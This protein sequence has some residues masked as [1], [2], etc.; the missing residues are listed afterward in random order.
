MTLIT[1]IGTVRSARVARQN[2]VELFLSSRLRVYIQTGNMNKYTFTFKITPTVDVEYALTVPPFDVA[3]RNSLLM[4]RATAEV[5]DEQHLSK[6]ADEIAHNLARSLSYA[7][8]AG[9][10]LEC[11]SRHAYLE[12]GQQRV[13][14]TIT[15]NIRPADFEEQEA[16]KRR[17]RQAAQSR[18]ENI[19]RRQTIDPNLRDMLLHWS[20]YAT[21]SEGRLHP[22]Y[23]VLQVA[24]CLYRGRK[25]VALAL[26][27]SEADL[28]DLGRISND[29]SV[30]NGRHPG[31]A[32][33]PHRVATESEVKT[34]ERVARSIIENQ[35]AKTAI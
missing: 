16:A 17:E 34:C 28:S 32:L 13:T 25:N 9:F 27:V 12:T 35:A 2:G 8:A 14:A 21:D 29:P 10:D 20:R 26:N 30:L 33:G 7:L 1:V 4:L 31:R 11:V 22:L 24:E 15:F 19:A 5:G 18:V 3:L 6:Q 23:D